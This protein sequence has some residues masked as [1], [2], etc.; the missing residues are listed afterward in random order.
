ML[1][2]AMISTFLNYLLVAD[3]TGSTVSDCPNNWIDCGNGLC[4]ANM[5]ACDNDNDCGNMKDEENC[6]GEDVHVKCLANQ[7]KCDDHCIPEVWLCDGQPDCLD[8][9]D[10][11]NCEAVV[12][13]NGHQ[14]RDLHC[15]PLQWTCDGV[16]DCRDG[17][18][19]EFCSQRNR[20]RGLPC[21]ECTNTTNGRQCY[22]E[23]GYQLHHDN[24]SCVDVNECAE[25]GFCSHRCI[26]IPGGYIC[27]CK[28]GYELVNRSCIATGPEPLLL[29]S[30]FE[31]IRGIHLRSGRHF[32]IH[33][34][35]HKSVAI[36]AD[37]LE[38]KVYWGE[39]SKTSSI[40]ST[41]I[42][43]TGFN[44][45]LG[46]GLLTPE[47]IAI[48]YRARNLYVTDSGLK[49]V[50]AC[51]TDGTMCH[52]LHDT[53]L[54]KPQAVAVD[55]PE[56][57]MYWSDWGDNMSGIFRSGMDGSEIIHMVSKAIHWAKDIAIDHTTDRLYWTDARLQTIEFITLDGV[58]RKIL[59]RNEVYHPYSLAVFEDSL[60]WT[61]WD[62]FSLN[63][64][65]KFTGRKMTTIAMENGKNVVGVHVYHP[66]LLRLSHNP[67]HSATCSHMCL[68][69]PFGSYRCVCSPGF[70]LSGDHK[71]CKMD[72][73]FPALFAYDDSKIFHVRPEGVGRSIVTVLPI[74]HLTFIHKVVHDW[75]TNS[76]FVSH[77]SPSAIYAV[78]MTSWRIREL[79]KDHLGIPEDLAFDWM[80]D[81]LYWV[82]STKGTIEIININTSRQYT[83][84][85]NL[86]NP[87]D[88]SLDPPRGLMFISVN[89]GTPSVTMYD[90][91]G[92][93][94]RGLNQVS[95]APMSL[96]IL[97]SA[98]RLFWVSRRAESISSLN[99]LKPNSEPVLHINKL[100][101]V[102]SVA[103]S[104]RYL[105][106]TCAKNLQIH[107]V[108]MN[109]TYIHLLSLPHSSSDFSSKKITYSS[110]PLSDKNSPGVPPCSL[111]N[112]G[113]S[114]LCVSAPEGRSCLCTT[115][116]TL[117]R[118]NVTCEAGECNAGEYRCARSRKC[119]SKAFVC[120]GVK[121]C[122]DGSDE[123]CSE[124]TIRCP[125]ND[126]QCRNGRCIF[127][128]WKCDRRDDCGD[129]S[130][131]E[132]CPPA[133]SC[134]NDQ[135]SCADGDCIPLLWRCDGESDCNDHS[136]EKMCHKTVCDESHLRCDHG[137]CI[138]KSWVCDGAD[139][140]L[141]GIDERNC[142]KWKHCS[143]KEF[144]CGDGK[145]I[146]KSLEC[147]GKKECEDGSDESNCFQNKAA[148]MHGAYQ[149]Q[150]G[151][152]INMHEVCDG[153]QDCS[154]GED[155]KNC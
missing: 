131:E 25:E 52:V 87:T 152:C 113:C 125:A 142:S 107:V 59:I 1:T 8:E 118:D 41:N 60:Y 79:V 104:E 144:L 86:S 90:M 39:I 63:T 98:S 69:A 21:S 47:G 35:I 102:N 80:S 96:T 134:A 116:M 26:N 6:E 46:N 42:D 76:L 111:K 33:K 27:I 114:H 64:C 147:N 75:K 54:E 24:K 70:I 62:R 7:F 4:V 66:V 48:D 100:R 83:I 65:N 130:D 77:T 56:G 68:T 136:D 103:V 117:S 129:N 37:P 3:L 73:K 127:S 5:W 2:I 108:K 139:D 84:V 101:D 58:T 153:Y 30:T 61:D 28:E 44:I 121:D 31:E 17:S 135:F 145:C 126:F 106:W 99:Y 32:L 20:C 43:G 19:E 105:Y 72:N 36:D 14:C 10:E 155:E 128:A 140:C 122:E 138:P 9:T 89:G 115:G 50:L 109:T 92:K 23:D 149:C 85:E 74:N 81:N 97:P 119:V 55:P 13:C 123:I 148:C 124:P 82:D 45:V 53:N 34:T 141:D 49:Q 95:G 132:D 110:I 15:I 78:N 150:D 40:Y 51:K 12:R 137:Q 67:C 112:G 29:L 38:S 91:D 11:R 18:D 154:K 151:L 133:T 57:F 146:D 71:T 22:C 16:R 93:N 120:D 94:P 143:A 88:I